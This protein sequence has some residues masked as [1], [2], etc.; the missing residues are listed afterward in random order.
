MVEVRVAAG[1]WTPKLVLVLVL[2]GNLVSGTGLMSRH[3]LRRVR[4]RAMELADRTTRV[5]LGVECATSATPPVRA[6]EF[7]VDRLPTVYLKV[8]RK[9]VNPGCVGVTPSDLC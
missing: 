8:T 9:R 4:I 3:S 1:R 2:A 5:W 6:I 7:T